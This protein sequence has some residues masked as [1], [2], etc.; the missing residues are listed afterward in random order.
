MPSIGPGFRTR[1][2]SSLSHYKN[3]VTVFQT[4]LWLWLTLCWVNYITNNDW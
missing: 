2:Q 3:I 1:P 4:I